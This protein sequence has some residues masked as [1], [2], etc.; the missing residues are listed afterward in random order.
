MNFNLIRYNSN[1][2]NGVNRYAS[3]LYSGLRE[4]YGDRK[5]IQEIRVGKFEIMGHFGLV[6]TRLFAKLIARKLEKGSVNHATAAFLDNPW[7]NVVTI[8]DVSFIENPQNYDSRYVRYNSRFMQSVLSSGKKI[9]VPSYIVREMVIQNFKVNEENLTAIHHGIQQLPNEYVES[10]ENPYRDDTTHILIF[11]GL[12]NVRRKFNLILDRL[13]NKNCNVFIIGYGNSP[14]YNKYRGIDNFHFMGYQDDTIVNQY[15]RYS[16]L[17]IYNSFDEGFGYIPLEVLRV[18]GIIL[19]NDIPIFRE[20]C[21]DNAYY[22]KEDFSDFEEQYQKA[23]ISPKPNGKD[24]V[25]KNFPINKMV[26]QTMK[27]YESIRLPE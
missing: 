2:N 17:V 22:Y 4:E 6:S 19:V 9:I 25:E 8:H 21:A 5:N 26:Q 20:M 16:D 10:L 12:D 24:Y 23:L 7:I 1:L 11:G 15:I 27:I 3:T 18:G 14:I 13:I